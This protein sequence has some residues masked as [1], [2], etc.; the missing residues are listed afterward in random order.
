MI[1]V[2]QIMDNVLGQVNECETH[3]EAMELAKRIISENGIEITQEVVDE[4]NGD[5]CYVSY[6]DT[7]TVWSVCIGL[8]E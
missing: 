3:E 2:A 5:G 6:K 8:T 4:L 7:D 1:V